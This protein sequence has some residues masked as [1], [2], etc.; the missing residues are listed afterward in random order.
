MPDRTPLYRQVAEHLPGVYQEDA[1]SWAQ[2]AGYLAP[3]DALLRAY[4]AQLEDVTTWLSPDAR[5]MQPPGLPAGAPATVQLLVSP[6]NPS[7]S[8]TPL[9]T[10]RVSSTNAPTPP[11]PGSVT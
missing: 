4:V 10:I 1:D 3:V 2:I 7:A 9:T 5:S 8:V 6:S 11:V